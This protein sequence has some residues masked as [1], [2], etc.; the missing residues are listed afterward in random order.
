MGPIPREEVSM[1]VSPDR[2][3]ELQL[4]AHLSHALGAYLR[5]PEGR[6][7]RALV[8]GAGAAGYAGIGLKRTMKT[9]K[10]TRDDR[11]VAGCA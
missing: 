5:Q 3:T 4:A 11:A 2:T 9:A 6:R 10:R 8:R 1:P 7:S